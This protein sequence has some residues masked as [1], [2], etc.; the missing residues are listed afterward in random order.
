ME[1]KLLAEQCL[2]AGTVPLVLG[3]GANSH[4]HQDGREPDNHNNPWGSSKLIYLIYSNNSHK[5]SD[6]HNKL[7]AL[8]APAKM[9][10]RL[11]PVLISPSRRS[12]GVPRDPAVQTVTTSPVQV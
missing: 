4:I 5:A 1:V 11:K 10:I 3:Q 6:S 2:S 8:K 7:E 12:D 9:P